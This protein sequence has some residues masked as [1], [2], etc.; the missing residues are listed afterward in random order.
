METKSKFVATIPEPKLARL[1]FADT[2]LAMLWLVIRLYVGYEW[3]M[4][5]ISK[6]NSP[7]W[8]G[9]QAGTALKGFLAG[10]LQKTV[11]EHPDVAG[12]YAS[13]IQNFV[14]NHPIVFSNLVVYGEIAVG[15][16]LILGL[17]TGIAAFFGSFMNLNYLLA[18]TVSTNPVLGILQLFL[19]LAW[20]IAGWYGLDR[21]ALPKL[22]TPWKHGEMFEK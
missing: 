8:L 22:G 5:G 1:L 17:F 14:L 3:L 21:F 15:L 11:G 16:G 10:A 13:F 9:E 2:R 4:A 19:I 7:A 18:G 12:W 20:R 6:L